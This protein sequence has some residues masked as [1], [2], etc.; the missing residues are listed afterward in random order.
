MNLARQ[1]VL[2][3]P[4]LRLF[5]LAIVALTLPVINQGMRMRW[6]D[7]VPISLLAAGRILKSSAT[8][9]ISIP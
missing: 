2:A 5:A 4:E 7:H 8:L 9:S 6:N 3:I 1:G